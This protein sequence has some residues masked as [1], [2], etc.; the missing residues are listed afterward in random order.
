MLEQLHPLTLSFR[1]REVERAFAVHLLSRLRLQ[2]RT[3]II[4]G[5]FIYLLSGFLDTWLVPPEYQATVWA[6]RLS[7]L[8]YTSL[9]FLL[10][11]HPL[12]ERF[13]LFPLGSTGL[14]VSGSL[15]AIMYYLP[16]DATAYF[17]P[18][19]ILSTFYTY[20]F[21][22]TRFIYALAIDVIII[23][24]YNL[25][26]GVVRGY[27]MPVLL[28]HDFF[29]ISANLIGGGAGYLAEYQRRLLFIRESELDRERRHHLE[30]SLHDRLTG[31]PNRELL[32][33]RMAQLLAGGRRG[34]ATHAGLFIDLDGFKPVNDRLGHDQGDIV[35]REMA[36][37]LVAAVRQTDTVS[38]LGG[39]EFFVLARD[40]DSP[41]RAARLADK[42]LASL[43]EPI[44]DVPDA[45]RIGASI[46]IA[47]FAGAEKGAATPA[48]IIRAAD[49]AMYKAK[50]GGKQ[51]H[52][53]AGGLKVVAGGST[54]QASAAML[55]AIADEGDE[56]GASKTAR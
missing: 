55:R 16:L 48:R 15:V 49:Q 17:Y 25:V 47:L 35:L 7:A 39:D 30:R 31:L 37:R 21:I 56:D 52:A 6:L 23:L 32:E 51:R 46:G 1:K 9:V 43:A 3:A 42:L 27:P 10:T 50:A 18:C 14:A 24:A 13:N 8:A 28:T 12:F 2:G 41:D 26:L 20:N 54:R 29:I 36:R 34:S 5:T 11:F 4:V 19:L 53:F 22:G 40:I 38:R 44:A 45:G 33:D